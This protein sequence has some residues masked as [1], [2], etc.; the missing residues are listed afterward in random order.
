[1][2]KSFESN[3]LTIAPVVPGDVTEGIWDWLWGGDSWAKP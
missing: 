2:K 1:M 3:G